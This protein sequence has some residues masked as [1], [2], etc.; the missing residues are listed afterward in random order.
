M[1]MIF[2]SYL[3]EIDSSDLMSLLVDI[4]DNIPSSAMNSNLVL[5]SSDPIKDSPVSTT[6]TTMEI[7][8]TPSTPKSEIQSPVF[9]NTS[10]ITENESSV[11]ETKP[12]QEPVS[13]LPTTPTKEHKK[14]NKH[15]N[16]SSDAPEDEDMRKFITQ[17]RQR[18]Y[19]DKL[20]EKKIG[21]KIPDDMLE[22]VKPWKDED[23][24]NSKE[25]GTF[26]G[27]KT[28]SWNTEEIQQQPPTQLP[29][30]PVQ[31]PQLVHHQAISWKPKYTLRHHLDSVR[32]IAFHP[33]LNCLISGSEDCTLKVW[34]VSGL[35]GTK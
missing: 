11:Q 35:T 34:N 15:K 18:G 33:T 9:N 8:T 16:S 5:P 14:K 26:F 2:K 32:S 27:R 1:I 23:N 4:P 13:E 29:P 6:P 21:A 24:T 12:K 3:K 7:I 10:T 20:I 17:L 31:Q 19:S 28:L 30:M 25:E 22:E